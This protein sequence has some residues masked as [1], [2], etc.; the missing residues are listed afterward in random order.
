ML[1]DSNKGRPEW[2]HIIANN[3]ENDPKY[4]EHGMG[5]RMSVDWSGFNRYTH[6]V[7]SWFRPLDGGASGQGF[8]PSKDIVVVTSHQL[9]NAADDTTAAHKKTY[10]EK[11]P[12]LVYG[13]YPGA[14]RI[15]YIGDLNMNEAA[16][17]WE[18]AARLL[19]N[20]FKYVID[21]RLITSGVPIGT[22][23]GTGSSCTATYSDK[24][25]AML[26]LGEGWKQIDPAAEVAVEDWT[27]AGSRDGRIEY[28]KGADC[29]APCVGVPE[30]GCVNYGDPVLATDHMLL[31]SKVRTAF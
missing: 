12:T 13:L 6:A 7:T 23:A 16:H 14:K 26:L 9:A 28:R 5:C 1:C 19:R 11:L 31:I 8:D 22:K 25:D 21:T 29:I 4:P 30:E 18:A 10:L 20:K 24:N 27:S 17:E 2:D 15:I 3:R